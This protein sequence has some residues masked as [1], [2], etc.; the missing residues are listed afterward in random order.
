MSSIISGLLG[1]VLSKSVIKKLARPLLDQ[2]FSWLR[3]KA[4]ESEN[5]LDDKAVPIFEKAVNEFLDAW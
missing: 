2:L 5:A 3:E 1:F 4:A